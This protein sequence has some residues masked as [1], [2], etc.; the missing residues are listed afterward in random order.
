MLRSQKKLSEVFDWWVVEEEGEYWLPKIYMQNFKIEKTEYF[1]NSLE[2]HE[3][4][5][6][7]KFGFS[8]YSFIDD[9]QLYTYGASI[10]GV[11]RCH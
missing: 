9:W 3:L 8:D 6:I 4:L 7:E 11:R 10:S 5:D 2:T 1:C